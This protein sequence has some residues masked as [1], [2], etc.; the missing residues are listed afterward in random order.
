MVAT[1]WGRGIVQECDM[2]IFIVDHWFLIKD[3]CSNF[4]VV[5]I[6]K[7]PNGRSQPTLWLPPGANLAFTPQNCSPLDGWTVNV[8]PVIVV[9]DLLLL[10]LLL[11]WLLLCNLF[12][13]STCR[14]PLSQ[15]YP[16]CPSTNTREHLSPEKFKMIVCHFLTSPQLITS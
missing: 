3:N 6:K 15:P 10:L 5:Q 8:V 13:P 14:P 4:I 9:V 16:P 11:L 12:S 7:L 1:T 2:A